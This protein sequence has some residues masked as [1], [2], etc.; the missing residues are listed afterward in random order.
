M[1]NHVAIGLDIGGTKMA[2]GLVEACS[3][4]VLA[5]QVKP[6][7]PERG[8]ET[9]LEDSLMLARQLLAEATGQSR[10]MIG[11][12]I[13]ICELVDP[14]GNITDEYKIR[15]K[16]L[17]VVERFSQL[18]PTVI[19]SD[20]RAPAVAEACYGA[21]KEYHL[22]AYVTVGTGI[23]YALVQ[24]K[25]PLKGARGNAIL[26][27][28][29]PFS[30][31]CPHCG[32]VTTQVLEEFASG[33]AMVARYNTQ[34]G[35][36][37]TSGHQLMAAVASGDALAGDIVRSAGEALGNSVAFMVN[38][39][40]PEAVIVG[41]GLG[42]AGGPYWDHFV[43]ATRRHIYANDTRNLP[44]LPAA[45]GVDAGLIGVAACAV[46]AFAEI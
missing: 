28:S 39:L 24:D 8:G 12:G 3:G 45:L 26:L 4:K 29:G 7:L 35:A 2:G 9:V 36:E 11:I 6:T 33:P 1:G 10:P 30:A 14:D 44:I 21:G 38:L 5:R 37:L 15:W 46:K 22:F 13:G 16:N 25:E 40:D 31:R 18:A 19:E 32:E 34:K 42:L 23:S 41:G 43:E 20:A 27:G 17:P